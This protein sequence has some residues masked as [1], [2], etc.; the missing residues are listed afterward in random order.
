MSDPAKY[1][2]KEEVE[3]HKKPFGAAPR[4]ERQVNEMS[5]SQK[6]FLIQFSERFLLG[7]HGW[8]FRLDCQTHSGPRKDFSLGLLKEFSLRILDE[9]SYLWSYLRPFTW[10]LVTALAR[11]GRTQ[12]SAINCVCTLIKCALVKCNTTSGWES[13]G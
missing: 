12:C 6:E 13:L 9:I 1:R 5:F 3:E 8:I 4:I 2:T 11:P 10:V 7:Y